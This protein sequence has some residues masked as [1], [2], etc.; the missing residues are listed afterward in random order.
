[1]N[2]CSNGHSEIA[3]TDWTCPLCDLQAD[4]AQ[5]RTEYETLEKEL[6]DCEHDLNQHWNE[7][8]K[9]RAVLQSIA[10]EHLL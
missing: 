5:L 3:Y 6:E 9:F 4:L 10:P 7:N 2:I 1:M 8:L